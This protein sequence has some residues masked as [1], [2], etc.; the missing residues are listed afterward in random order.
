MSK[1]LGYV[2]FE[3]ERRPL[4]LELSPGMGAKDYSEETAREIDDEIRSIIDE[5]R[6]KVRTILSKKKSLLETVARTLLEKETIE[7]DD[8]RELI[9]NH[10]GD[11][12]G[13]QLREE[14]NRPD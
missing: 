12:E 7:G 2:T 9:K 3:R 13:D 11:N 8:L 14:A 6:E 5:A 10:A 1:K 4:F